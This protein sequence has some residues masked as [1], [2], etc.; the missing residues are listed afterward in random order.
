MSN[1]SP[2]KD[3]IIYNGL[4]IVAGLKHDESLVFQGQYLL[5][6]EKGAVSMY[7]A[8]LHVGPKEYKVTA[9]STTVLPPII[10]VP[11]KK[12]FI[13]D[14]ILPKDS[15]LSAENFDTVVSLTSLFTGLETIPSQFPKFRDIWGSSIPSNVSKVSRTFHPVYSV[16]SKVKTFKSNDEWDSIASS[17]VSDYKSSNIPPV[18]FVSGPKNA[19]KSTFC[20]FLLNYCLSSLKPGS[21]QFLDCDLGQPEY[22]PPGVISLSKP[23]ACNF[24]SPFAHPNFDDVVKAHS[25]GYTSAKDIPLLYSACFDDLFQVYKSSQLSN[26]TLL[27]VNTPGWAKGY[28]L[29]L[30]IE[31]MGKSEPSHSIFVGSHETE[32]LQDFSDRLNTLL[33]SNNFAPKQYALKSLAHGAENAHHSTKLFSAA[34]LRNLQ[35]ST[36][37]CYNQQKKYFDVSRLN[38]LPSYF[39]PFATNSHVESSL[40]NKESGADTETNMLIEPYHEFVTPKHVLSLNPHSSKR[41]IPKYKFDPSNTRESAQI[42]TFG[43]IS[44]EGLDISDILMCLNNVVVSIIAVKQETLSQISNTFVN[45]LPGPPTSNKN[46]NNGSSLNNN[47]PFVP[48]IPP[49]QIPNLLQPS[50]TR[51]LGVALLKKIDEKKGLVQL[52]TS[53]NPSLIDELE[54]SGE[55]I[56][57]IRGRLFH[58]F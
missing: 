6:V 13:N 19:G 29:E 20:R 14:C 58:S 10:S 3:N 41:I 52:Q 22:T 43:I 55:R 35:L 51:S 18:V 4:S 40:A 56:I 12:K 53:I 9:S 25:L 38:N 27:I 42:A 50:R 36:Y 34:D 21:V 5:R 11:T 54:T 46:S 1:F 31:M 17:V 8:T 33:N 37:L 49:S 48:L 24:S 26:P 32:T 57:L 28:G 30:L 39:I 2:S 16:T 47:V 15:D 23:T 45:A 44:A 7:G